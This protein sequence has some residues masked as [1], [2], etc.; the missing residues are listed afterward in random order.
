[1]ENTLKQPLLQKYNKT[2]E[3]SIRSCFKLRAEELQLFFER[4][5]VTMP[6]NEGELRECL[7]ILE[8]VGYNKGLLNELCTDAETGIIGDRKDLIRRQK[9]YGK[10]QFKLPVIDSY[11]KLLKEQFADTNVQL[12][13]FFATLS[14]FGSF[15]SDVPYKYLESLSI[16]FAVIFAAVITSICDFSKNK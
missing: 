4:R 1:M 16:Y 3:L 8:K 10:N 6:E 2:P 5:H 15:F 14:L 13:L 12:L 11:W 9:F 7:V